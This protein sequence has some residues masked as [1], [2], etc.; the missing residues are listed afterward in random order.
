M[1][2]H[3]HAFACICMH[4]FPLARPWTMSLRL[5]DGRAPLARS[6]LAL[7]WLLQRFRG[8]GQQSEAHAYLPVYRPT[9]QTPV[10]PAQRVDAETEPARRRCSL[11]A[12]VGRRRPDRRLERAG[13]PPEQSGLPSFCTVQ[14]LCS[15]PQPKGLAS[16]RLHKPRASCV[17][18]SVQ[19]EGRLVSSRCSPEARQK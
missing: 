13:Y 19:K 16:L 2:T 5:L 14:D 1:R 17:H 10:R 7:P 12:K 15:R 18:L 4:V 3:S 6:A 9:C 11:Q 8:T